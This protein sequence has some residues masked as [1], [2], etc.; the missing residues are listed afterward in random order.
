[1]VARVLIA[2]ALA[3]VLTPLAAA[4]GDPAS[5]VLVTQNVFFPYPTP[6]GSSTSS[7]S[8]AVESAYAKGYRVKVAVIATQNDLG[9]VPS[10]FGKPQ[11]YAQFLGQELQ[12]YYVGP[13]LIVMPSG[14]GIYDGGRTT[15]AEEKV[16]A[17]LHVS[18]SSGDQLTLSAASA[19][20]SLLAA[21]ALKSK[22]VKAPYAAALDVTGKLGGTM[23]LNYATFDDSGKTRE[24]IT[25]S[26]GPKLL[27]VR[28]TTMRPTRA[29][30][31]YFVLWHAPAT[32]PTAQLKFCVSSYDP[33]GHKS[34]PSCLSFTPK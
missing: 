33:S 32:V 9:S 31:T 1:V 5:D 4:D 7:L 19:V 30:K 15:A 25:V 26:A 10:L 29:D 20:K 22:D 16:L 34:K 24:S 28:K 11:E 27:F 2:L 18:G 13:L 23:R 3:L 17:R 12:S 8:G 21:G 6:S 14:F